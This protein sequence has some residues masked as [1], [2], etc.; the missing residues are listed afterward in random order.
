L[1]SSRR[2]LLLRKPLEALEVRQLAHAL[3]EKWELLGRG[4]RQ[5]EELAAVHERLRREVE[6]R[7][8][9]EA[10]LAQAQRLESLGRMASGL[11]HELNNPLSV[12]VASLG[13][14]RSEFEA[15]AAGAQGLMEDPRELKE[16][17]VDALTGAERIRRLI[18]DMRLFSHLYG[19]QKEPVD[20]REALEQVL[21][22]LGG[23]R[24]EVRVELDF[25]EVPPVL[26]SVVGLE[27]VFQR[28]VLNALQAVEGKPGGGGWVRLSTRG[29]EGGQVEVEVRDN[30]VGISPEH[31][32]R[33]FEPFFTTRPPGSGTGLG[34]FIC[35]GLVRALGGD[36]TVESRPGEGATFRVLLP[37]APQEGVE[38]GALSGSV[39]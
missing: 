6:A 32:Q 26:A 36:I 38:V 9:L 7:E 14:L 19:Q 15:K 35:R 3:W 20:V 13:L 18:H 23:L 17:C 37:R 24:E 11:A 10:R 29:G 16:V 39:L 28:L 22:G 33:L 4:R 2:L 1:G 21:E 25:Q 5:V 8:Q 12:V 34:L 31:Q 30:G 27:Q